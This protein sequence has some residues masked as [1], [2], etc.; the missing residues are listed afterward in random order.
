M[1]LYEIAERAATSAG[2]LLFRS[3]RV[4]TNEIVIE[5]PLHDRFTLCVGDFS[6]REFLLQFTTDSIVCGDG[7]LLARERFDEL[8][9]HLKDESPFD[10]MEQQFRTFEIE[11]HVDTLYPAP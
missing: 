6:R 7:P 1:G 9:C 4:V 2:F 10:F 3:P 5:I 8:S 11:F